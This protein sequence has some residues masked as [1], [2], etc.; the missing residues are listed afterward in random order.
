MPGPEF[1][2]RLRPPPNPP[3]KKGVKKGLAT[4]PNPDPLLR[5]TFLRDCVA[6]LGDS[7]YYGLEFHQTDGPILVA[8]EDVPGAGSL[9]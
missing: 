6:G 7:L 3:A 9:P 5:F 2:V 4:P 8:G 1:L